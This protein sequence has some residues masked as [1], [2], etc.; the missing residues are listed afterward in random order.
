MF[1]TIMSLWENWNC[2]I[3]PGV[4]YHT[5]NQ[6][7]EPMLAKFK[8]R[9]LKKFPWFTENG[10]DCIRHSLDHQNGWP[11][12]IYRNPDFITALILESSRKVRN[13]TLNILL[14]C[15]YSSWWHDCKP[16]KSKFWWHDCK[17]RICKFLSF[18]FE[19]IDCTRVAWGGDPGRGWW[20]FL[21]KYLVWRL[22]GFWGNGAFKKS[23]CL[24]RQ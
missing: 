20:C 15:E 13:V 6:L 12:S 24:K 9:G 1:C 4:W 19:S 23:A 22:P 14:C 3:V 21:T 17:P 5:Q 16:R 11:T 7:I 10:L 8:A 2:Q 18:L